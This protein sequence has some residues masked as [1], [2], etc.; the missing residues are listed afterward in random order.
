M[1][2]DTYVRGFF[3]NS[4]IANN[5][6]FSIKFFL[7]FLFLGIFLIHDTV[8]ST[9]VIVETYNLLLLFSIFPVLL[10]LVSINNFFFFYFELDFI[11]F[12]I[13][14]LFFLIKFIIFF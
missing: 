6:T 7:L 1:I 4:I 11:I 10:L 8:F 9:K 5:Y 3:S 12:L 2:Q 14:L 13:F